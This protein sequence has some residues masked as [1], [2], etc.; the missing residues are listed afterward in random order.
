MFYIVQLFKSTKYPNKPKK[1]KN[2]I[3]EKAKTYI[4]LCSI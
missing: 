3:R 2:F 4:M 1:W